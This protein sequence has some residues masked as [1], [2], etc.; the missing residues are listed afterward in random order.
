M[1]THI[2]TVAT[3][4]KFY[5]PYLVESCKING[6]ELEVL[7]YGEKWRG[8]NWRFRIMIDYLDKLPEDDVVCFVDG[9]DVVCCRDLH[10]LKDE[11]LKIKRETNCK[12]VT[13]KANTSWFLKLLGLMHFGVCNDELLNAGTYIGLV[14]DLK[15]IIRKIYQNNPDDSADDQQLMIKHCKTIPNDY[16]VDSD[17]K[18]FVT[19]AYPLSDV[20][21]YVEI[22]NNKKLYFNGHR[23]FFVH[24]SGDG[25]LDSIIRDLGYPY[26][27]YNTIQR[28]LITNFFFKVFHHISVFVYQNILWILIFIAVVFYFFRKFWIPIKLKNVILKG[29]KKNFGLSRIT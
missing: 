15:I 29:Y 12:I 3:E 2:V 5:F 10:Q 28:E 8:Y 1:A 24:S 22:D 4:S 7:G 27:N 13:G 18:L 23:P 11:F 26:D 9:Y 20:G 19:L 14:K 21:K 17:G 16:L 6:I 25:F